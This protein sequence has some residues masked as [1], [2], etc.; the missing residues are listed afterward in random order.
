MNELLLALVKGNRDSVT[1]NNL[2]VESLY[3][4]CDREHASCNDGCLVYLLNNHS[5]VN[6]KR[7]FQFNRGCDCFK[8]GRAM[9]DFIKNHP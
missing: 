2:I 7:G 6:P 9:F 4:M 3:D 8:N 1:V 5:P